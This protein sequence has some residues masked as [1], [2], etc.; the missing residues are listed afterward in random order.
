M[1]KTPQLENEVKILC[2]DD[3][4]DV[5]R[6]I[7]LRLRE[8]QVTVLRAFHGMQG[9]WMAMSEFPDLIITDVV[10]P[11]GTGDYVV[12]TLKRNSETCHIPI[13]VLSGQRGADTKKRM[14][15]L[16]VEA[17]LDKP[18]DP[19]ELI[20]TIEKHVTLKAVEVGDEELHAVAHESHRV[21]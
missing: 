3:D 6:S 4:P 8:Y 9:F 2:I 12:E 11:Q 19:D 15:S 14:R 20:S 18:C 13:I 16:G 5:T 21:S 17:Y 1:S 10:M 7:E